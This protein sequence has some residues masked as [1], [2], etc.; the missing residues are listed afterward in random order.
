MPIIFHPSLHDLT[1]QPPRGS[2]LLL[3]CMDLR[4]LDDI[5]QF[6]DHD[7]LGN[8]YDHV[9]FAGAAYGALGAPGA[10]DENGRPINV[11]YWNNAFFDHLHA[12]V[13]LHNVQDVYILEHRNCGAYYKYF[14]VA[15]DFDDSAEQRAQEEAVHLKYAQLLEAQIATWSAEHGKPLR[16]HTFLMELRGD[17]RRLNRPQ[18]GLP[19]VP[20]PAESK[21]ARR[22]KTVKVPRKKAGS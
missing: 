10:R 2:V 14:H 21:P 11:S 5:A 15:K 12:A 20:L 13:E 4:L 22:S 17:V 1:Y 18:V 9:V 16:T 8:R 3:S 6:M 19:Q 7:N